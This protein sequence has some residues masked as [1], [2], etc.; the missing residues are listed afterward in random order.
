[1][2]VP[3]GPRQLEPA[4]SKLA[5]LI[6]G[7]EGYGIPGK[8]PTTHNNPGDLRHSPHSTH[9]PGHP[10]DIGCIDTV[11]DGWADLER[12]LALYASRGLTLR[13]MI[14]DYYAPNVENNSDAY[15]KFVCDGLGMN[16]DTPVSVALTIV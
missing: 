15:L 13:Q 8:I 2:H 1:M 6:A 11:A 3:L 14:V 7:E 4:V 5:R 12:Q 10:D 16:A 9:A